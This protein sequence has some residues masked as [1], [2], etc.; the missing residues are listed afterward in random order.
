MIQPTLMNQL[1]ETHISDLRMAAAASYRAN[2]PRRF[3]RRPLRSGSTQSLRKAV[4]ML[5]AS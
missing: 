1:T 3:R 4:P 2:S 5:R